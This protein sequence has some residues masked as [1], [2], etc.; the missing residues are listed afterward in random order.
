[1]EEEGERK[2]VNLEQGASQ[3]SLGKEEIQRQDSC[4]TLPTQRPPSGH[5]SLQPLSA[6]RVVMI[7]GPPLLPAMGC[8]IPLCRLLASFPTLV[9]TPSISVA[10]TC[11]VWGTT[12]LLHLTVCTHCHSEQSAHSAYMNTLSPSVQSAEGLVSSCGS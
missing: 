1:M 8:Y 11:G 9:H 7:P 12:F 3:T 5:F 6:L 10:I 4:R 2:R